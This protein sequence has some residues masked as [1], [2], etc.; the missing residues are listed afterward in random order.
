MSGLGCVGGNGEH[1]CSEDSVFLQ[2]FWL[3]GV[4]LCPRLWVSGDVSVQVIMLSAISCS[5]SNGLFPGCSLSGVWH[6]SCLFGVLSSRGSERCEN[7]WEVGE[8]VTRFLS[9]ELE[10]DNCGLGICD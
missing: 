5:S 1:G 10:V 8:F 9:I 7:D 2:V 6:C 3:V 4:G